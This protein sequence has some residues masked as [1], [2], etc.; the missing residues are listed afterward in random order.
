MKIWRG[1]TK[2]ILLTSTSA[3]QKYGFGNAPPDFH[4]ITSACLS[5][6]AIRPNL[7]ES[8]V[9]VKSMVLHA[10]STLLR[11]KS[12]LS[13]REEHAFSARGKMLFCIAKAAFC[14]RKACLRIEKV[15][16]LHSIMQLKLKFLYS[17]HTNITTQIKKENKQTK[18]K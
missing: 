16:F 12:T 11:R 5:F 10:K 9:L 13:A 15:C 17:T 1:I 14:M 18:Q 6:L 7:I 3:C 2:T 8:L 4:G